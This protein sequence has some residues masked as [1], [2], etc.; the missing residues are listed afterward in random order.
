MISPYELTDYSN[1]VSEPSISQ[2]DFL[3]NYMR[4]GTAL[5]AQNVADTTGAL[6]CVSRGSRHVLSTR[7][8][9]R[10]DCDIHRERYTSENV[11]AVPTRKL[12]SV[13]IRNARLPGDSSLDKEKS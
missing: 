11:Q 2:L 4:T 6:G 12:Q 13:P 10:Y 7:A 5:I 8:L 9:A 3:R 1:A